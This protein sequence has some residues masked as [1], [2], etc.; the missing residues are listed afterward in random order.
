MERRLTCRMDKLGRVHQL[1]ESRLSSDLKSS[2]LHLC[3][4][5]SPPSWAAS[6]HILDQV[7]GISTFI[8]WAYISHISQVWESIHGHQIQVQIHV[9]TSSVNAS[10]SWFV[11]HNSW[12][13]RAG[14]PPFKFAAVEWEPDLVDAVMVG[15]PR[16]VWDKVFQTT[17]PSLLT[18]PEACLSRSTVWEQML[19]HLLC[20]KINTSPIV[21][22][23][24]VTR[25]RDTRDL[26]LEE[27]L[28]R[29]RA[30]KRRVLG[31]LWL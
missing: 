9:P 25:D 10:P 23:F 4:A 7:I 2:V 14:R 21:R 3:T 22:E 18:A 17:H 12:L 24:A 30:K 20:P 31:H 28:L 5:S 26:W 6:P 19:T 1:V 16:C 15:A 8:L 11:I 29:K 13:G 27:H